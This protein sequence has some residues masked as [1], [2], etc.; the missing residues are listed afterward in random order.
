[1]TRETLAQL[2]WILATALAIVAFVLIL[3][4]LAAQ[5]G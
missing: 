5:L 2:V 3:V 4:R 1:M